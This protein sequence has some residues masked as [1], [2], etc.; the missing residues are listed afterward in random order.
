MMTHDGKCKPMK[1]GKILIMIGALNW[2]LIGLG[3]FLGKDLNVVNAI[4]GSWPTI[5]WIVYILVGVSAVMAL[6]GCKCA[7]C[8]KGMCGSCKGEGCADCKA[9]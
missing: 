2:G 3:G 9:S 4:L 7:M 1:I 6:M 8:A 5:E